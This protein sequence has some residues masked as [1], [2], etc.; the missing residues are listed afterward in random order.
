M[1]KHTISQ[2]PGELLVIVLLTGDWNSLANWALGYT[3][4]TS[5]YLS[6]ETIRPVPTS[7]YGRSCTIS[8]RDTRIY[9]YIDILWAITNRKYATTLS[10]TPRIAIS[11]YVWAIGCRLETEV[12]SCKAW[13][14]PEQEREGKF[15][16]LWRPVANK[17]DPYSWWPRVRSSYTRV[18][19]GIIP[20]Y[21]RS[22]FRW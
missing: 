15:W 9:S 19:R 7:R 6:I 12:A 18:C 21:H 5:I 22:S 1:T 8:V 13:V 11:L 2:P 4:A 16:I 3:W 10:W 14:F 17:C 20:V